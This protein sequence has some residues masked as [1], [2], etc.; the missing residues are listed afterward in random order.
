MKILMLTPYLP[1][2]TNSGGQIRSNNLIKH[3]SKKH[4]ITLCSLIKY[5]NDRKYVEKLKPFCKEVL[6]FKRPE[7]PW[8]LE[9][10]LRTGF[11]SYPFLVMRNWARGEK[12]ALE[13]LIKREKFDIIHAETFYVMPHI[14]KTDVPVVLVDQ[15]IEYQVYSHYVKNYRFPF[16]KPLLYIDVYKTKFW[17]SFYWK[18]AK[19]VVAVSERDAHIMRNL[20]PGLKVTVVPNGVGEDL[21]ADV[22]LHFNKTILFMGS[23]WLQN[24]EAASV[25]ANKVFPLVLEKIPDAKLILAGQLGEKAKKLES[26]NIKVLEI[27]SDDIKTQKECF[28]NSGVMVAPLYGPGGTR[29][30]ILGSMAARLPVV[31]TKTGI[32]GIDADNGEN[33]LIGETPED[34]AKLTI[35]ILED[36]NLYKKVADKARKFVEDNYFYEAIAEKL[37]KVYGEVTSV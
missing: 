31:T 9:N 6:I 14:P 3:L 2:P 18:K 36:K 12:R 23:G 15:T 16:L 10:I 25:L 37:D 35:K 13:E 20:V 30:K 5:E 17:E 11:N 34:L 27:A 1:Y 8:T 33:V 4:E 21:T 19:H 26:D 32:A 28:R 22:A 29:L 24:V 7:K